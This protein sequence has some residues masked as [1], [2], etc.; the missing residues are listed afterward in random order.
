VIETD[1]LLSLGLIVC[2]SAL[3]VLVSRPL[4]VPT[5]ILYI[6]AG[7]VLGPMTGLVAVTE[8]IES[9]SEVGIALLL[10][11]VGMELNLDK[12]RSVGKV[13]VVAGIGQV[14]FTAAGG[15]ILAALLG[16][17]VIEAIFLAVAL[18]FSSTVVVVKLL[19]EKGELNSLYGRIAVGIFLVQDVV[20]IIALTF[21]S[22]LVSPETM[23]VGA[24]AANLGL[25]FA[26]MAVLLAGAL[27]AARFLLGPV[28]GWVA[29]SRVPEA[30]FVWSLL[31][32]FI[33]VIAAEG[34]NLSVEIGAFLAGISLAQLPSSHD[35]RRRVHP[36]VSFFIAVFFVSLGIQMEF[37]AAAAQWPAA[38]ALSLFVLIG[39]PFIF[40]W[41]IAR[42]RY[43][44][45]TSFLTS[46][47]VAQISEFSFIFAALGLSA[48][49]IDEG[50][51]SLIAVVG[52][53]TIGISAY[54][55]LY[56]HQLY[57]LMRRWGVLRLFR[58][59]QH[60]DEEHADPLSGHVIVVGINP[61]SLY[62]IDRLVKNGETVLTIDTDPDK[63]VGL[64]CHTMQG[65]AA[66]TS[67][68]DEANLAQAKLLVSAL[69]IE[70]T[71][72][73]LAFRAARERVPTSIHAF[74]QSVVGDLQQ[75]GVDYL[76]D[77]KFEGTKRMIQELRNR[78]VLA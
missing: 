64:P 44:E 77:S 38:V 42:M 29:S 68:L 20:V 6:V 39:N 72:N 49:V 62:I 24:I 35:L 58:A 67:V 13:A 32:C 3:L 41:I 71:N 52:L 5:I 8:V 34:L 14:V 70:N 73:I 63:L 61:L 37:G 57:D 17:A 16:F 53:V 33:F 56:N 28:F 22:G 2:A 69:Q 7:L 10:F 27:L 74:D 66:H 9:I 31:W 78:G 23:E 18:T 51:L 47:T 45:R 25:A 30:A 36:L 4:R 1:V 54:M 12:I 46:V 50:I 40:M 65:N 48:G 21:L 15:Y 43:S 11:L 55:I 59:G 26:G 75:M 76:I 60:D 19:D